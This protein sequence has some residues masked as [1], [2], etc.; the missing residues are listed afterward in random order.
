[1]NKFLISKS[2]SYLGGFPGDTV[3]KNLLANVV[4]TRDMGSILGW[5][6][7]HPGGGNGYPL[8]YACLEN[9]MDGGV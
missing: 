2:S 5:G 8:M 7:S 3:M 1:M 6:R 9:S 4:D